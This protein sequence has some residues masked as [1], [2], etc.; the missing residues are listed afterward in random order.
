MSVITSERYN[1]F[2]KTLFLIKIIL[3]KH[4]ALEVWVSIVVLV[5]MLEIL[6][7][8]VEIPY[9]DLDTK[10]FHAGLFAHGCILC[11]YA[12]IHNNYLY[13]NARLFAQVH[14]HMD[15]FCVCTQIFLIMILI[16]QS[17][18]ICSYEQ[19]P[20]RGMDVFCKRT[21]VFLSCNTDF[22]W[23]LYKSLLI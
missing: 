21:Q 12:D 3:L 16:V 8:W 19:V 10:V 4:F 1:H 11:T 2:G 7:M 23:E 20:H 9:N 6:R 22:D 13:S 17:W 5:E 18:T 15:V 14:R